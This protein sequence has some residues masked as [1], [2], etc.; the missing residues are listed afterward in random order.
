MSASINS[1]SDS[2]HCDETG[3]SIVPALLPGIILRQ[4]RAELGIEL[5]DI[6]TK[7]GLSLRYLQALEEDDYER[8]PGRVYICGYLRRYAALVKVNPDQVVEAF[9]GSYNEYAGSKPEPQGLERVKEKFPRDKVLLIL[10]A[11]VAIILI[12]VLMAFA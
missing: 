4:A 11:G 9:E 12:I 1:E 7:T 5:K 6:A 2:E 10:G 8:L 3:S